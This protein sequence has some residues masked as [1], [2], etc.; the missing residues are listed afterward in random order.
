MG[1]VMTALGEMDVSYVT[2]GDC[3]IHISH[4]GGLEQHS[5]AVEKIHAMLKKWGGRTIK[6]TDTHWSIK[7]DRT[8]TE[9][10]ALAYLKAAAELADAIVKNKEMESARS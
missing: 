4:G 2:Q 8:P 5:T 3:E 10:M 6:L 9:K 7:V 1:R